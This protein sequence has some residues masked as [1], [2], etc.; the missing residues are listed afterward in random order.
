[1]GQEWGALEP[2]LFFSDL[3]ADLADA[4]GEGRRREFA[5]FPEFADPA[6]RERIPD[7]QAPASH[8]RSVLDW[9][10]PER[11]PHREWL[12]FH[13]TLLALRHREI[14]PLLAGGASPAT[15]LW[16]VGETGLEATWR[17]PGGAV[18]RLVA[19]LGLRSVNHL[20]PRAEWGRPLHAL[21][22]PGGGWAA[23]PPWSA[24]WYRGE[25][26]V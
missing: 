1:M 16:L 12:E 10:A 8:E 6:A 18:L 23:L 2:F 7:P 25:G 17:F 15:H 5:R 4:V 14:V 13:R 21:G 11:Q 20:G 9:T 24:A 26:G 19:N 3:G 22:L